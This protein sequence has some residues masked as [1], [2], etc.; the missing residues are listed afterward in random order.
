MALAERVTTARPVVVLDFDGTVCVGDAPILAYA[1][2]VAAR[3]PHGRRAEFREAVEQFLGGKSTLPGVEDG[4]QAVVHLVGE[5]LDSESLSAAYLASRERLDPQATHPPEGLGD[6]LDEIR[7]RGAAVVL[8]TNAPLVGV[9]TWLSTHQMLQHLDAVIPDAG[10]PARMGEVL[11][12][13]LAEYRCSPAELASVGD[14]WRNDI[15]PA[16]AIGAAG[17][18]IDRYGAGH[19]PA[20]AAARSFPELYPDIRE[21][22]EGTRSGA[23]SELR[24]GAGN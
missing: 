16:I 18:Y 7:G 15:E 3:L 24:S 20:T 19:G 12:G 8:V 9:D 1:D 10:K 22:L 17:M 14:V 4:Y 5:Q 11:G 21:W 6:F 2:E 13:I 23:G